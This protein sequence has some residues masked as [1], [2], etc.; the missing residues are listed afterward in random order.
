MRSFTL[1]AAA[2]VAAVLG[3]ASSTS[4]QGNL[5]PKPGGAFTPA[6]KQSKPLFQ[7]DQLDKLKEETRRRLQSQRPTVECGM[8][9]IPAI[10]EVDPKSIKKAPTDKKYTMRSVPRGICA[11]ES[12]N[13]PTVV[14]STVVV[15]APSV[16]PR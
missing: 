2:A 16:A 7:N 9:I 15:P 5:V 4:A 13:F 10:P 14:P 3:V 8:T 12:S 6:P 1:V 11:Q